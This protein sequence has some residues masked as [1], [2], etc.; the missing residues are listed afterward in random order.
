MTIWCGQKP[1]TRSHRYKFISMPFLWSLPPYAQ[2]I[3]TQRPQDSALHEWTRY[4]DNNKYLYPTVNGSSSRNRQSTAAAVVVFLYISTCILYLFHIYIY[5]II[6]R[7]FINKCLPEGST[8]YVS[9]YYA[10]H[11]SFFWYFGL[12]IPGQ[13]LPPAVETTSNAPACV[14]RRCKD[15]IFPRILSWNHNACCVCTAVIIC[16]VPR[17]PHP[18]STSKTIG[19]SYPLGHSHSSLHGNEKI[20]EIQLL[21]LPFGSGNAEKR[22]SFRFKGL[23]KY[24]GTPRL[25]ENCCMPDPT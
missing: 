23:K 1:S 2:S 21:L 3:Y 22:P 4:T 13:N 11:R 6:H 7:P 18:S 5:I 9:I 12:S 25:D 14:R 17:S 15:T 24:A 20:Q 8:A 19:L 16:H 10:L